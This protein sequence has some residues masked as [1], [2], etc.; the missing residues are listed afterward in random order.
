MQQQKDAY[1][2]QS[3]I[4]KVE[5][6]KLNNQLGRKRDKQRDKRYDITSIHDLHK[7][8]LTNIAHI[9]GKTSQILKE[10]EKDLLR[11]FS[12]RLS[13]VKKSINQ[14]KERN[15]TSTEWM[16]KCHKLSAEI[17][18]IRDQAYS[19]EAENR[20]FQED[21]SALTISIKTLESDR[22]FLIRQLLALK[23]QNNRLKR[24]VIIPEEPAPLA[25]RPSSAL[26][27]RG[28]HRKRKG[29]MA[30]NEL[31]TRTVATIKRQLDAERRK[32]KRLEVRLN[33][34]TAKQTELATFI[35][36]SIEDV[37]AQLEIEQQQGKRPSH[38]KSRSSS[39]YNFSQRERARILDGRSSET[40]KAHR[41]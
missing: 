37:Q 20:K 6:E 27:M 21:N 1:E 9:Q 3:A 10:Q 39:I 25:R 11:A 23:K 15:L 41:G 36:Q 5:I 35:K 32:V 33:S 40:A 12:Q 28:E 17:N 16:Q 29:N 8:I 34:E 26:G 24:P 13:D 19:I 22:Q 38:G 31:F 14:E 18:F 7:D 30:S 2:R 4:Q